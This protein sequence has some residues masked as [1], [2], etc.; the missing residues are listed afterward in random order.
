MCQTKMAQKQ[1][2]LAKQAQEQPPYRFTNLYSVMHWDYW[3]RCA[4]HTV[5]ARP[6]SSTAGVDGK[7]RH[8]F[9]DDYETQIATLVES[10]R[11]K[12]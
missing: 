8:A 2:T 3:L 4:A 1:A 7:T 6:G 10:L 11:R 9:K 12:T 5:L